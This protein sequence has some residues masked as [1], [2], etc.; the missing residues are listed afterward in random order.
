MATIDELHEYQIFL[1]RLKNIMVFSGLSPIVEQNLFYRILPYVLFA[2]NLMSAL[3]TLNSCVEYQ[4]NMEIVMKSMGIFITTTATDLKI[5]CVV[6]NWRDMRELHETL[7]HIFLEVTQDRRTQRHFLKRFA[8][9]R[10][11]STTLIIMAFLAIGTF[12]IAPI[13]SFIFQWTHHI[14]PIRYIL[15][16]PTVYP[17]TISGGSYSYYF[18]L[19][20]EMLSCFAIFVVA[21]SVDALFPVYIFQ[22]SGQL[23]AMSYQL[24]ALK[25]DDNYDMIIRN[26]ARKHQML[27]RCRDIIEAVYGPIIIWMLMTTAIVL[28]ALTFQLSKVGHFKNHIDWMHIADLIRL[29]SVGELCFRTS[30][31]RRGLHGLEDVADVH[32]RL[33]RHRLNF[34]E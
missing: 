29:S 10:R 21:C 11:L 7:D 28:C 20:T 33:F 6:L 22:I 34:S 23:D 31:S 32:L 2:V 1:Q 16:L 19:S 4:S 30:F 25:A 15:P 3:A 26:C 18:H 9:A 24:D 17:W 8:V 27:L 5:L 12:V 13:A 14:H